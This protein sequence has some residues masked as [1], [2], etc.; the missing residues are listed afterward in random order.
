M[1]ASQK[2]KPG[3]PLAEAEAEAESRDSKSA[4]PQTD[5]QNIKTQHRCLPEDE[6]EKDNGKETTKAS[7][8]P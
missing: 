1:S 5:S 4:L 8:T 6:N 2:K 7:K 3:A